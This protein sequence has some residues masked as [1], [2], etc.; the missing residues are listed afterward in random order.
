MDSVI[1]TPKATLLRSCSACGVK[2]RLAPARL[3]QSGRCGKCGAELAPPDVPVSVTSAAELEELVTRATLPVVVDFWA[4][5]CGPCVMTA[6]EVERLAERLAGRAL[7]IKVDTEALPDAA[8][9]H[10]VQGL[11]TFALFRDG[12]EAARASGARPAEGIAQALGLGWP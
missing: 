8:D 1:E 9:R 6:P 2:N 3:H 12:K 11:P 4:G 5:W 10:R 7:V